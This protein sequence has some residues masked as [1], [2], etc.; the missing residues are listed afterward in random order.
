[1]LAAVGATT[2]ALGSQPFAWITFFI[3][4][5]L[6]GIGVVL[7]SV[8][9]RTYRQTASPP[10][11][12]PRVMA[13]VRF[14]SWGVIPLGSVIGGAVAGAT[15]ARTVLIASGLVTALAPLFLLLT[16]IARHRSLD[17]IV[18]DQ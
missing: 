11:M 7:V 2:L 12:L 3:G 1:M 16:R 15:S 6:F 18:V 14:V 10:E 9:T 5:L 13:T 17:E 4:V 8:T